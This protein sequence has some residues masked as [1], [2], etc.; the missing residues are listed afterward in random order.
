MDNTQD[1]VRHEIGGNS[2][3]FEEL[4]LRCIIGL[5]QMKSKK[6]ACPVEPAERR[7]FDSRAYWNLAAD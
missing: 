6:V 2:G 3:R 7:L 5:F 4:V 1:N